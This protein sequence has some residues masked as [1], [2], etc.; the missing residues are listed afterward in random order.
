[1][2]ATIRLLLV[3]ILVLLAIR[4]KL[5]LGNAFLM[6]AVLMGIVFGLG[7]RPM[8][9]SMI[10]SVLYP[11]TL[12]LSIIV[13]LI[14]I[15][16]SSMETSGHMR[17]LLLSFQ[18]LLRNQKLNLVI[19]PALIGLL[20]MPGGA[21]FSAPMVKEIGAGTR[22]HAD[23]MSYVNYWFR[24]I[25]E[26]WWPLYPGVLLATTMA[27]INLWTFVLFLF[28]LT[29][30]AITIGYQ[31]IRNLLDPGNSEQRH[32]R[33]SPMP[34]IRELLPILI[35]IVL[36]LGLGLVLSPMF[37]DLTIS[38]EIGLIGALCLSILWV[39][40]ENGMDSGQI[41]NVILNPHLLGMVY[42]V[43]A[44][45]IFKG[46]LEDS[47][48]VEAITRELMLIHIP[49]VLI[50]IILPFLVGGVVGITIAF[51]GSTFPILIALI[52]S[53]GESQYILQ[54]LMLA[55]V[56]GFV[57]VLLSPLHLCLLLS[58]KY[59]SA[60]L[61]SVYRHLLLPAVTVLLAG[62][63]YFWAARFILERIQ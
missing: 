27:G 58:N 52:T 50:T 20:P 19:F 56:S 9:L 57:G 53:F 49:V 35:V 11:K 44:I 24:H 1:M 6:G 28:P 43:F 51:V 17:R 15:L 36:G 61:S 45:L 41:R 14:L 22:L 3:F 55:L 33:P 46:I 48:A 37:P 38:K 29:G 10:S 47:Q 25:W 59:F 54:Y 63:F 12:S 16:S 34:F 62:L 32:A 31:P 42:M 30:V 5:S 8:I 60:H 39:W 13:S 26:Y 18:G 21:I 40:K 2:P 4:K 7:P 23:H